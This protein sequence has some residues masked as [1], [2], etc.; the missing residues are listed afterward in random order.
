M[1]G[2]SM[3]NERQDVDFFATGL[4]V[5]RR[6]VLKVCFQAGQVGECRLQIFGFRLSAFGS[7]P[8]RSLVVIVAGSSGGGKAGV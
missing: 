7:G 4:R 2:S 5:K 1:T 3:R 8:R 6:V